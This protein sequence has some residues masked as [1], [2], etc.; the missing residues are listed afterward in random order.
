MMCLS[1]CHQPRW[2]YRSAR[3]NIPVV[4]LPVNNASDNI[5]VSLAYK[6][7][8]SRNR[9]HDT[10]LAGCFVAPSRLPM[11]HINHKLCRQHLRLSKPGNATGIQLPHRFQE[12]LL[13][14][15]TVHHP[16]LTLMTADLLRWLDLP[17]YCMA[18]QT[19]EVKANSWKTI[20]APCKK[21]LTQMSK[22]VSLVYNTIRFMDFA[23]LLKNEGY[24]EAYFP[25]DPKIYP[26]VE[27]KC[28]FCMCSS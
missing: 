24:V 1:S 12:R 8:A 13:Q 5:C 25:P 21:L 27:T 23:L 16:C 20:I 19:I 3:Q 14:L 28:L 18:P 26:E 11:T 9:L 4:L 15:P 17:S 22:I 10:A 6:H 7:W 2:M